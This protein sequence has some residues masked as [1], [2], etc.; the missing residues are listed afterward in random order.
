[1]GFGASLQTVFKAGIENA[2]QVVE[3]MISKVVP[4]LLWSRASQAL[5]CIRIAWGPV[6]IQVLS[7]DLRFCISYKFLQ[8]L[9]LLRIFQGMDTGCFRPPDPSPIFSAQPFS[10]L[11]S[12]TLVPM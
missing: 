6:K 1:M 2:R 8:L 7:W 12:Q 4:T 9:V 3:L 10:F 11:V 5:L